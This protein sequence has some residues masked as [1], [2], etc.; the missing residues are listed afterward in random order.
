MNSEDFGDEVITACK[1][2]L[3]LLEERRGRLDKLIEAYHDL[4]SSAEALKAA[5]NTLTPDDLAEIPQVES[6]TPPI[7]ASTEQTKD[8]PPLENLTLPARSPNSVV[9]PFNPKPWN[10]Q[11]KRP[12]IRPGDFTGLSMS[13]ALLKYFSMCSEK[14]N[15]QSIQYDLK[16]GGFKTDAIDPVSSLNSM[17]RYYERKGTF[18]RDGVDRWGL[19]TKHDGGGMLGENSSNGHLNSKT[20]T[21]YCVEVLQHSGKKWLHVDQILQI[22]EKDYGVRINKDIVASTLRKNARRKRQ[23][24]A[25][26]GNRFGLLAKSD[27]GVYGGYREVPRDTVTHDESIS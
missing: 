25:F 3:A 23:F 4:C 16:Q 27:A 15:T 21:Q 14:R 13:Q 1:R 6:L 5:Q 26:G 22:L 11:P 20:S 10:G 19:N 17:L 9:K 24:K 2:Q 12:E 7:L 18:E 8:S